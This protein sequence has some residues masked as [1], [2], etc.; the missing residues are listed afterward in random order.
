MRQREQEKKK[1]SDMEHFAEEEEE[2]EEEGIGVSIETT[3]L[4]RVSSEQVSVRDQ[5]D[6]TI[7]WSGSSLGVCSKS[8]VPSLRE[9]SLL[10][11]GHRRGSCRRLKA[12]SVEM[13]NT[14]RRS[15]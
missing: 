12:G 14:A 5:Q 8:D 13:E 7:T 6:T 3:Y 4:A 2:E 1:N 15:R 9:V 11:V 10:S